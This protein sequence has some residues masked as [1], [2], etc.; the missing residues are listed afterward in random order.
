MAAAL[1]RIVAAVERVERAV[2]AIAVALFCLLLSVNVLLRYAFNAPIYAEE[3]CVILMIWM[4]FIASSLAIGSRD[5]VAVTL[6]PD[7]LPPAWQH[8]LSLLVHAI[9]LAT[10]AIFLYWSVLWLVSPS[11]SRDIIITLGLPKWPSYVIVP[12]FFALAVLKSIRNVNFVLRN[13][14]A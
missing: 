5:M 14:Q 10:A 6:I 4:A 8:R 1:D 13:R 2:C 11:A 9:V 12:F 3:V 7:I